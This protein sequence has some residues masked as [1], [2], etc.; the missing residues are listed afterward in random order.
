MIDKMENYNK[1]NE[2]IIK[3]I[4]NLD[5]YENINNNIL[6]LDLNKVVNE[7]EN[8]NKE[9]NYINK[10]KNILNGY[11]NKINIMTILYNNTENGNIKLFDDKFIE[12][13]KNRC[14][15]IINNKKSKL[16]R[17][18]KFNKNGIQKMFQI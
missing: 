15:L 9:N 12:N 10:I 13:N 17:E 8:F 7:I 1:I 4:N 11:E 2:Y 18:Y 5:N 3:S 14:Y 6:K 16:I